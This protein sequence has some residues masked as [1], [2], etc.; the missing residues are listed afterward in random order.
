MFFINVLQ[1]SVNH[2]LLKYV[3]QSSSTIYMERAN[4]FYI[5]T[6]LKSL[7]ANIYYGNRSNIF[8]SNNWNNL[9]QIIVLIILK[10]S[11][12]IN[13][14]DYSNKTNNFT[15]LS[16]CISNDKKINVRISHFQFSF[17]LKTFQSKNFPNFIPEDSKRIEVILHVLLQLFR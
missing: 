11:F 5:E 2:T 3:H 1:S 16:F 7:K 17:R 13:L 10:M 8:L 12:R 4:I 9:L 6:Y 15:K 14:I